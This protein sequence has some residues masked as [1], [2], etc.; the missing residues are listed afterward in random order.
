MRLGLWVIALAAIMIAQGCSSDDL[1]GL[2]P[3]TGSNFEEPSEVEMT[4][5]DIV[6]DTSYPVIAPVSTGSLFPYHLLVGATAE[7]YYGRYLYN[8]G[9][10][11]LDTG[12]MSFKVVKQSSTTA[13]FA[14]WT[15]HQTAVIS[16]PDSVATTV[17][18]VDLVVPAAYDAD[19][20]SVSIRNALRREVNFSV[21]LGAG[22]IG[23]ISNGVVVFS[24][25]YSTM[26]G[27]DD[28]LCFIAT[29]GTSAPADISNTDLIGNWGV[30]NFEMNAGGSITRFATSSDSY[31][32]IDI[33]DIIDF[34]AQNGDQDNFFG[35][36]KLADET[37]GVFIYSESTLS[38][39][40]ASIDGV[41]I[42]GPDL[43]TFVRFDLNTDK[44]FFTGDKY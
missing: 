26:I 29:R 40:F 4:I 18:N 5:N 23:D 28:K 38:T 22:P 17:A 33:N 44:D 6:T 10:G 12:Y 16:D 9:G 30:F 21:D 14:E 25:D 1:N 31:N 8:N 15:V 41:I 7:Y 20:N 2:T 13:Y 27:G 37:A 3:G 24:K 11:D 39:S 19:D 32:N 36:A 43:E 35:Q 34:T 42:M